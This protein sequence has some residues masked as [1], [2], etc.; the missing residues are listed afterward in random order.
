ME[1]RFSKYLLYAVGEIIL[2]VIGI[3]IAL[4]I[5]NSNEQR[6]TEAKVDLVF[7][8]LIDEL[9]ANIDAVKRASVF[10]EREDSLTY[11]V[12][13]T[14]ISKEQYKRHF[15]AFRSVTSRSQV[16]DLSN[17][18]YNKLMQISEDVPEK[19]KHLMKDLQKLNHRKLYIDNLDDMYFE[20]VGESIE[21]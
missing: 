8:E 21:Y 7:E 11:L 15:A 1:N 19:Y 13:N 12:L 9:V 17:D 5:N 3:L 4:Y 18:A 2:V 10:F 16:I 6:K 14:D 20:A